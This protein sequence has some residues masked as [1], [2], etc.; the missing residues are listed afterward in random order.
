MR[1]VGLC[2]VAALAATAVAA[3]SALAE[4]SGEFGT[5]VKAT[6]GKYENSGCTKAAKEV[7]KEKFEWHALTEPVSFSGKLKPTTVAVLE[8]IK[9]TKVTCK[10]AT[11]SGEVANTHEVGKVIATFEGCET[12]GIPCQDVGA[13]SGTI[14]TAAMSGATGVEKKG[15]TPP[16]NNKLAQELHPTAGGNLVE[17]E[18]AGLASFAKGSLIHPTSTG[19]MATKVTEKFAQAKGEQKPSHFEGEAEDSHT[20]VAAIGGGFEEEAATAL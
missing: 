11:E 13:A 14:V 16:I 2:L 6:G 9:G 15:T 4:P 3:T 20:L 1:I 8:T 12:G 7:S 18:C 10:N 17:F 19:K 5:C